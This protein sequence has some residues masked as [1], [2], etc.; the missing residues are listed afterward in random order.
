MDEGPRF[1]TV[2]EANGVV[3]TLE[4]EFGRIAGARA[5]L[6]PLVETLGGADVAV[7][8]L[9]Q[10]AGAPAGREEDAQRLVSLAGE[11]TAAVERVNELGC[12]VKDL[13]AGLV[14]FYSLQDGEPVFLCWQYGER[15]VSHWH[16]IEEGFAGRRPIAGVSVSAPAFLN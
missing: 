11:I 2:D 6:A 3:A 14:D 15:A 10:G 12:L 13:E 1:F 16:G 4:I 7:A 5:A 9:Q 8:I